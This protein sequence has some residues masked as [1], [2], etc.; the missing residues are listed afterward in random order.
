[1]EYIKSTSKHFGKSNEFGGNNLISA[2]KI[3]DTP[4]ADI[5]RQ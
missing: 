5:R 2:F 4:V 1:M 3:D